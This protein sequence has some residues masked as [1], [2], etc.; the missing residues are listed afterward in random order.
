VLLTLAIYAP[1]FP[2]AAGTIPFVTTWETTTNNESIKIP[3]TGTG[4]HYDIDWG[5]G[6]IVTQSYVFGVSHTY[7]TPGI[8]TVS[9]TGTFP[10]IYFYQTDTRNF[11][12]VE[13]WGNTAWTSM[14]GAFWGCK[15]LTFNAT[16]VPDLSSVTSMKRMFQSAS[17]FNLD[18]TDWDVS[19]VTDMSEMFSGASAF[20]GDISNWDVSNVSNMNRMFYDAKVFNGDVSEWDVS[21]VTD[22]GEMFTFASA[23]NADISTWDVSKVTNMKMMF[24]FATSFNANISNWNVGS[25]TDM[26][27]MFRYATA[28]DADIG[29]WDVSKVTNMSQM[30]NLHG[31][32]N[33]DIGRWDV[34][35]VTDM[36]SMFERAYDF[37]QSLNDWDVSAVTNMKKMFWSASD[38]NGNISDWDVSKVTNMSEMF[39][40]SSSFNS[41]ISGWNV[42]SLTNMINMFN[43][44]SSFNSELSNWDVSKVTDF[45]NVFAN[46]DSFNQDINNW[47]VSAAT[48]LAGMFANADAFNQD[49]DNWD[50]SNVTNMGSMFF[51]AS[52]FNG[53]ISTWDVGKVTDM[54]AMFERN[55]DFSSD[56]S[57]WDVSNVTNM[58]I[59]FYNAE[60]FQSDLSNWDVSSVTD[61]RSMFSGAKLF[62]SDLNNWDV[63][64]VSDMTGLFLLAEAF[65]SDLS[66][67]DVSSVTSMSYMFRYCDLF[68]GDVSGWD[69][70]SVTDLSAMF[71]NATKFDRNLGAWDISNVSSI[72]SMLGN[73]GISAA[74]YDKTLLGWATLEE[75]ETSI[76]TGIAL[77]ANG[78][79]YCDPTGRDLLTSEPYGWVITND[80]LD[81]PPVPDEESLS[82]L[83]ASCEVT[84]AP[85]APTATYDG[86]TII[87]TT[88]TV[89]PVRKTSNIAWRFEAPNDNFTIQTQQVNITDA[90]APVPN[91]ANLPQITNGCEIVAL[92]PPTATDNCSV[93]SVTHDATLPIRHSTIITWTYTDPSGNSVTQTQNAVITDETG[94]TPTIVSLPNVTS[95]C[96]VN[97]LVNPTAVDNCSTVTVT[98]N[99]ELPIATQGTTVITW[100]YTDEAG[101]TSTQT[102]NVVIAD[103][104][105]PVADV[106]SLTNV[107]AQCEVTELTAIPTATDN[108]SNVT[109]TNDAELPITTQ[110]TTVI[111]WT[112]TDEFGNSSTQ[113]QN[114]VISDVSAPVADEGSL[115]NIT[116]A[117]E[118]TELTTTPTATDNCS[119]VTVTNNATLPITTQGTT[120]ITWT[121]TDDLG[122]SSTQTQNVVITDATAPVADEE[123]L[124]DVTAQ[125]EVTELT[126]PT[127]TDNCSTVTV[128]RDTTLPITK[129]GTTVVT[130]TYTDDAG[131]S[132]T[133]K[134]NVVITDTTAP[135][136][137]LESLAD[138]TAQCE[139]T[140]LTSTPKATDN[141]STVTVTNDAKLPITKQGTTVVTWTYTDK[142]G[143]TSTQTQNIVITDTTAPIPDAP[144][145]PTITAACQVTSLITPTAKDNC[146]VVTVTN[147]AVFPITASTNVVWTYTDAAGNKVTITQSVV[148]SDKV[149]PVPT[150]ASLAD[151]T[152]QCEVT[153]LTT[154]SASDNC[155]AVTVT[156]DATLP[157]TAEGTTVVTWTY[158]D[159]SGNTSTQTQKVIITDETA[160]FLAPSP[161]PDITA[162]CELTELPEP[163]AT[164]N[165]SAVT[166]TNDVSLPITEEGLT[167]V[168]WTYTDASGNTSNQL[169]N[170]M[171]SCEGTGVATGVADHL[172]N[173]IALFPNPSND[174]FHLKDPMELVQEVM[175]FD[176][177]GRRV[178]QSKTD[179]SGYDISQLPVG[180]YSVRLLLDDS[181]IT[182]R[183]IKN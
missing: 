166:V 70:S 86:E 145:L 65:Q 43:G 73:S 14:E 25:V 179:P 112:Y 82:T 97:S 16:D 75:N 29:D 30:F 90:E 41:D 78:L 149:A 102:Q 140:K 148:I 47:N 139:V 31:T 6:T 52:V 129:Q 2:Q 114:V 32:F 48:T 117:C 51:R 131:N 85:T 173:D 108:C 178:M 15:N 24:N 36:S 183:L 116:A 39:A 111:T 10:R 182:T 33:G 122:N 19:N 169:Q 141:C 50:V 162:E 38:F 163:A 172:A 45:S 105:A 92:T 113:I 95:Q 103:I 64:S 76:P 160:P 60:S 101:N 63:S 168:T 28:F 106:E 171:I 84:T 104:T 146:G 155:G 88:E 161:L 69:V 13:Q 42:S 54:S 133:Q 66:N 167:I 40:S 170:V 175:I 17:S 177:S 144:S 115:P 53:D 107:T 126:T 180:I 21:K 138:I 18:L 34:G 143:N 49:L 68:N 22:M 79:F 152:S 94:P 120:V 89:F 100:T 132:S 83:T 125:C 164:D 12:S 59:M 119:N 99:A 135:V 96:E 46:A 56:L 77:T 5:D 110:G 157:I 98:N 109:V 71:E 72:T 1:A 23:F 55:Y 27:G 174:I 91:I 35:S 158:A 3:T 9:I 74:N 130:W 123:S 124:A 127:A 80:E 8:Y 81:C 147:D 58:K 181:I 67:W 121:Y 128:T 154:P 134:Q 150:A 153:T 37:N 159:G 7:S 142:N 26:S 151:V 156:H 61:M 93:E 11:R 136:A 44:A 165:C 57:K 176:M 20:N 4:Y 137:D 62:D 87:A 118:V